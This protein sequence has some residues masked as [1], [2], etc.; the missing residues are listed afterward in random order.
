M[1]RTKIIMLFATTT[2]L[3]L[4]CQKD[5]DV[6]NPETTE[7]KITGFSPTSGVVGTNITITGSGFPENISGITIR[8]DEIEATVIDATTSQIVVTA[9]D[10]A[11][12]A[13]IFLDAGNN[14]VKAEGLFTIIHTPTI[15]AIVPNSGAAGDIVTISGSHFDENTT[16]T[17]GELEV[18]VIDRSSTEIRVKVPQFAT[19]NV[20]K[21]FS[22]SLT[23]ESS[24]FVITPLIIQSL[25]TAG[26][27]VGETLRIQGTGFS[28]VSEFN[29]VL[30]PNAVQAEIITSTPGEI[31]IVIPEGATSGTIQVEVGAQQEQSVEFEIYKD[32]PKDGLVAFFPFSGN[33]SSTINNLTGEV[34][35][36]VSSPDR[37]GKTNHSYSFDGVNDVIN[38]GN[39]EILQINHTITVSAWVSPS[40]LSGTMRA[41]F[42]KIFFDPDQGGNPQGGFH[43]S[44]RDDHSFYMYGNAAGALVLSQNAAFEFAVN[45]WVNVTYIIDGTD[46]KLYANGVLIVSGSQPQTIYTDG[47]KGDFTIGTYGAGFNFNG[48]ID[49]VAVYSKALSEAE[50]LQ[51]YQQTISKR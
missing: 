31:E 37:F 44:K 11:N 50:V 30:F 22:N 35:G 20:F 5:E 38:M 27:L 36:A 10:I 25:S 48:R 23:A 46:F 45:Q 2:S 17:L 7:L 40:A 14:V 28:S 41:I 6:L 49:D 8:F 42:T 33:A 4:S 21:T 13:S 12:T 34:S 24:E 19:T 3:L 1:S 15:S 29:K 43:L 9:P 39:P 16:V 51:L 18:E 47:S 32:I 26:G